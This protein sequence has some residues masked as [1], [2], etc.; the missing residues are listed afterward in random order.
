MSALALVAADQA[1]TLQPA[2]AEALFNRALALEALGI[3]F[4]AADSWRRYLEVDPSS[5]W[6]VEAR[7]RQRAAEMPT[8]DKAWKAAETE[9][10]RASDRGDV[11]A[12][13]RS[14]TAFHRTPAQ[15]VSHIF[16]ALGRSIHGR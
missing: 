5:S 13:E 14:S 16:A 8:R 7:E 6:A 12:V 1:L 11:A 15:R 10:A 4:A 2:Q 3:R 9:L